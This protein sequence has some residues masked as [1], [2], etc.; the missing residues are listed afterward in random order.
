MRVSTEEQA[1]QGVSLQ[2]QE[3]RI[4]G[5]CVARQWELIEVVKDEGN[6]VEGNPKIPQGPGICESQGQRVFPFSTQPND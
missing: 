5:Q 1:D 4:R 2:V 6:D 3:E